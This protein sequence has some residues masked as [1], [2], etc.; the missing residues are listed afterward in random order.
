MNHRARRWLGPAILTV[1]TL[2]AFVGQFAAAVGIGFPWAWNQ[3]IAT[4]QCGWDGTCTDAGATTIIMWYSLALLLA[5]MV[6]GVVLGTA[7]RIA[8]MIIAACLISWVVMYQDA[9]VM[10]LAAK[11]GLTDQAQAQLFL[12]W[13]PRALLADAAIALLCYLAWFIIRRRR[14]PRSAPSPL[15]T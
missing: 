12:T 13:A 4:G 9:L 3:N 5:E 15:R 10:G 1:F 11:P 7:K 2:V 14:L 8:L 6:I